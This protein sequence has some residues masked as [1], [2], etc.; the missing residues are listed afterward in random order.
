[1]NAQIN[2]STASSTPHRKPDWLMLLARSRKAVLGAAIATSIFFFV[3][4]FILPHNYESTATVLPP[5]RQ[6]VGGMLSSLL[7]SNSSAL[8]LL[9]GGASDNPTLDLF[10][11]IVESRSV[12]ED[13]ASD[14]RIAA[15]FKRYDTTTSN[16]VRALQG[17]IKS[18]ALRTGEFTLTVELETPALP[19]KQE[20]DSTKLMAA[21]IANRFVAEL[22][23]FNRDRLLTSA[24]NTRIFVEEEYNDRMVQLDS[25]Y[26]QLQAFQEAHQ[27]IAL[28]EQLSA[29]VTA[30]AKLT[31]QI[32]QLEMQIGVEERELGPN[33]PH[34]QAL[35][36]ELAAEKSELQ[37]YDDGGAG[38][39]ILALK[40]VPELS[41]ELAHYLREVKV[42]EQ[43]TAYLRQELEQDRI[44]EQ[45]DLPS[46]QVLDSAQPP[47]KRSSPN[48]TIYTI[49]GFILGLGF[50]MGY[51]SFKSFRQDMR[52][53]PQEHYRLLNLMNT[54]R[55]GEKA[56]ILSPF[57]PQSTG[58]D[59]KKYD[60]KSIK[61]DVKK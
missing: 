27:A 4:T 61:E 59:V 55:H 34:M 22:D 47:K 53:R 42:L 2:G 32:E 56:E 8:S 43:V 20:A 33:S 15:F 50:G 37:K 5:E 31:S 35:D 17:S 57:A 38:E 23:R 28:P 26:R 3:L 52:E 7:S 24:R 6:G 51:V 30:A 48:R 10:K 12:A 13:V 40:N 19:S 36:A 60:V 11:T 49:L 14:R 21:Y 16:I 9:K 18:E 46:L 58:A 44:S 25:A 29:T 39:Y 54:L 45:R 41:R 1:M